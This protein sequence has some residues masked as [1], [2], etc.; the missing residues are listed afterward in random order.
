MDPNLHELLVEV[1]DHLHGEVLALRL[2]LHRAVV[3]AFV[4]AVAS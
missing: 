1:Q 4:V 3:G 2:D